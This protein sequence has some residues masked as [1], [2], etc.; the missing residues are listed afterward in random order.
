MTTTSAP[1]SQIDMA[2]VKDA[3]ATAR[4][5]VLTRSEF[6][7]YAAILTKLHIE[8]DESIKTAATDGVRLIISPSFIMGL[9]HRQRVF[10][11]MHE[12]MHVIYKHVERLNNR[13]NKMW[14]VAA[15]Y[16]INGFLDTKGFDVIPSA[17]LDHQYDNMTA[18]E[19]YLKL[20]DKKNN[21]PSYDP[22]PD[23]PDLLPANSRS[24]N[25]G[26]KQDAN[27]A[28]SDHVDKLIGE[29]MVQASMS[30]DAAKAMANIPGA[31][32]RYYHELMNP[33]VDWRTAL[34]RFLHGTAKTDY[35]WKR[36]SRRGLAMDMYLPS[37]HGESMDC[38]DFAIDTSGSVSENDFR[39]FITEIHEV[40]TTFNP[41][42]IGIIQF[43]TVIQDNRRVCSL[44]DFN[45][46]EFKGG[47]GTIIAPVMKAFAESEG[48]ALVVLTD[49]YFSHSAELDPGKPVIWAI[50]DNPN[51][52][53]AFGDVIHFNKDDLYDN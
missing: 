9:S 20:M 38:I 5:A 22:S 28:V 1:T 12:L 44:E 40:F 15:D 33:S 8:Y 31:I 41:E 52:V 45:S 43:D 29:A 2:S 30:D 53:P 10:L 34:A 39:K 32:Q 21:D 49:G 16:V 48:R 3:V 47:G 19:V 13:D 27:T 37:L 7:F 42:N 36:P 25:Q 24:D 46:I 18:D 51:F 50:Y 17:L 14:N 35:S 6:V 26:N 11:L 4:V 23:H